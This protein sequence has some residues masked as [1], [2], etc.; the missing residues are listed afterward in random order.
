M[1]LY[2]IRH[3]HNRCRYLNVWEIQLYEMPPVVE[4][5]VAKKNEEVGVH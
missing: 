2:A 1:F 4:M 3:R 5:G